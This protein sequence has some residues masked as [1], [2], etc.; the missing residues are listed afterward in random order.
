MMNALSST[1]ALS[2]FIASKKIFGF[3]V[4]RAKPTMSR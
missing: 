2:L 1:T 3:P 4:D